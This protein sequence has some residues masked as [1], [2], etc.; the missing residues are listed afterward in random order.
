[1]RLS[2]LTSP[3]MAHRWRYPQKLHA[4]PGGSGSACAPVCTACIS[5]LPQ[6]IKHN[7]VAFQELVDM[8][9]EQGITNA[10]LAVTWAANIG[11]HIIPI[12]G[13]S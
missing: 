4:L 5:H 2:F 6:N 9:E 13:S 10:Q 11:P 7:L 8:A 3:R 1:M 12:P